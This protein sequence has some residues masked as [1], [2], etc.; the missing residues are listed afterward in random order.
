[1][2]VRSRAW[3]IAAVA[4][5]ICTGVVGAAVVGVK[6]RQYYFVGRG[7]DGTYHFSTEPETVH[8]GDGVAGVGMGV[9][10]SSFSSTDPSHTVDVE[11]SRRDLE[12][13]DLLRQQDIRELVGVI[14]TEVNGKLHRTFR[15]KYVLADGREITMGEGDPDEQKHGSPEQIQKDFEEIALLR[16]QGLR[17]LVEVIDTQVEGDLHRTCS[18]NYVLADGRELTIGEPDPELTP[19]EKMLRVEQIQEIG[20]LRLLK[21]GESLGYEDI[22]VQGRTFAFETYLFTLSDGTVVTNAVGS[23]KGQE[24]TNLTEADWQ[25]FRSL[26]RAGEGEDLGIEEK[27]V[28][29]RVFVFKR[30]LY[31]LGD[32]TEVIWASG[33]PR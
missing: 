22:D 7:A 29:G 18:Y 33:R 5:L 16:Q 9:Q 14:E 8:V 13:I 21:Q 15:F 26:S 27:E 23:P 1:M 11:Q 24:K 17:E 19:P 28:K 12:E 31:I 3:K 6:I 25:E 30:K 4:A 10:M 2:P 20:R 32:G